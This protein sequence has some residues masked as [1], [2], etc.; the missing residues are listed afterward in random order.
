MPLAEKDTQLP[1]A[2]R[3]DL[4]HSYADRAMALLRQAVAKGYKDAA[5]LK[6][7]KDLDPLR[8]RPDFQKLL[9][10]LEQKKAKPPRK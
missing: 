5:H 2:K 9:A 1:A 8:S 7:D 4:A 10:E 6:K 3:R